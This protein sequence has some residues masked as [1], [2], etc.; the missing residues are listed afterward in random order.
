MPCSHKNEGHTRGLVEVER[1]RNW[2]DVRRRSSDQFAVAAIH[3]VAQH[4]KFAALILQSGNA[5]ST[6]PAVMHWRQHNALSHFEPGD[7]LADL[8]HFAGYI[9]AENMRQL[10]SRQALSHPHIQVIERACPNSH[11]HLILARL[12]L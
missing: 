9:T 1:V 5:L 10:Y 7:V 3:A 12:R 8:D 11:Q 2:N 4:S 6:V